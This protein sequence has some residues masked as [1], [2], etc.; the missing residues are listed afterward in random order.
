MTNVG[1]G[2]FLAGQ[3]RPRLKDA[4]SQHTKIFGTTTNAHTIWHRATIFGKITRGKDRRISRGEPCPHSKPSASILGRALLADTVSPRTTK[5]PTAT[6]ERTDVFPGDQALSP[7]PVDGA[8]GCHF[9]VTSL[10][11][12]IPFDPERPNPNHT[13]EVL[14]VVVIMVVVVVMMM[15]MMMMM[16]IVMVVVV[17][18]TVV[19]QSRCRPRHP[20]SSAAGLKA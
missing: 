15:M 8:L 10:R 4:R 18:V 12:L 6:H 11:T 13:K 3:P 16:V 14:V 17:V 7:T 19:V 2:V 1:R 5:F 20:T 9:V